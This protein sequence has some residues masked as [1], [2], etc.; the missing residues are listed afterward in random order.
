MRTLGVYSSSGGTQTRLRNQMNRLFGCTVQ[1]IY[2]DESGFAR[3]T[4]PVAD[5]HEFWWNERKPGERVLWDSKIRLGEAFFQEIIQHPVPLDM[6]T[7]TALK[8]CA[9]GLDLYLWTAYRT[10][11]LTRPLRLSWRQVYRQFG[12]HP[13][14]ANNKF[15]VRSFREKV[16]RELKKIKI[17]WPGL[18]YATPPGLLILHPSTPIIPPS[19]QRQLAS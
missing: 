9:L 17:A 11:S 1:L 5:K 12:L 8:R 2:A 3:V 6:N 4:S 16:L 18:N 14:K 19:D 7:L 10:F 13:D 15:T